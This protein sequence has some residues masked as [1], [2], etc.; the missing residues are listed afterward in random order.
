MNRD[1]TVS[2]QNLQLAD[3]TGPLA[4]YPGG[5]HGARCISI[6]M[7]PSRLTHGPHR[8]GRY[9]ARRSIDLV[10]QTAGATGRGKDAGW[11]SPKADFPTALGNPA[12]R[13]GFPLS[14]RLGDGGLIKKP[15]ISLATK[16]GHFNLL[17]T[18]R[19]R[20]VAKVRVRSLHANLGCKTS[21]AVRTDCRFLLP[22]PCARRR[23]V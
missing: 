6:W 12:K 7:E 9:T 1:N 16:S 11:K 17:R 14:H 5:L 13:A 10:N 8:L 21:E 15:D 2:F 4:G 22:P 18:G 19:K 3:R 23:N 20:R